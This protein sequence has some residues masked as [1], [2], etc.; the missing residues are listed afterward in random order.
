MYE[1][2]GQS[3]PAGAEGVVV[4]GADQILAPATG[5]AP[6]AKVSAAVVVVGVNVGTLVD[7]V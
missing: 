4:I 5:I 7:C 3:V 1:K 6:V 2:S